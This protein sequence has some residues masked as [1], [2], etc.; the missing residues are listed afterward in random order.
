VVGTLL[1]KQTGHDV[2]FI[3]FNINIEFMCDVIDNYEILL[4]WWLSFLSY[5]GQF[6]NMEFESTL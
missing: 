6:L 4:S 1:V 2:H 3:F 5:S